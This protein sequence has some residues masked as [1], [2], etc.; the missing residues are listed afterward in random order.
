MV[1]IFSIILFIILMII[2]SVFMIYIGFVQGNG[3]IYFTLGL[4]FLFW[5]LY[6]Y[7]NLCNKIEVYDKYLLIKNIFFGK[8]VIH[9]DEIEYWKEI[10]HT[11]IFCLSILIKLKG[12]KRKILI[13][14]ESDVHNFEQLRAKLYVCKL[15]HVI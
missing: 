6:K 9:Y 14:N 5:M 11:R 7:L 2:F 1:L 10:S 4:P 12:K 8:K 3:L 13:V 15:P